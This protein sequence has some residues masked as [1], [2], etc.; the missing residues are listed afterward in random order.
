M[1][2][3]KNLP[4]KIAKIYIYFPQAHYGATK[5]KTIYITKPTSPYAFSSTTNVSSTLSFKSN[6]NIILIFNSRTLK[7]PLQLDS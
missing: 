4:F 2:L 7:I 1:S 3:T 5:G 6:F